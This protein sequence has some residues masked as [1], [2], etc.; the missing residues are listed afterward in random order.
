M[1]VSF[2]PLLLLPLALLLLVSAGCERKSTSSDPAGPVDPP[3][4]SNFFEVQYLGEEVR[5]I[6][7]VEAP[8]PS[9]TVVRG[10]DFERVSPRDDG[11][12]VRSF[13]FYNGR[14]LNVA[15]DGDLVLQGSSAFQLEQPVVSSIGPGQTAPFSITFMPSDLREYSATLTVNF[16]PNGG[17]STQFNIELFGRG[18]FGPDD[19]VLKVYG[20]LDQAEITSGEDPVAEK[21]SAFGSLNREVVSLAAELPQSIFTIANDGGGDMSIEL[22]VVGDSAEDFQ[23]IPAEMPQTPLG[24]FSTTSFTVEF[25]PSLTS[26]KDPRE[27]VIQIVTNDKLYDESP[28]FEVPLTGR[29][30]QSDIGVESLDVNLDN[31]VV[32]TSGAVPSVEDRTDMGRIP[33]GSI[34]ALTLRI[35]N[36]GTAELTLS[37]LPPIGM[38]GPD[39][40][41]ERFWVN[42]GDL[43]IDLLP[44]ESSNF[45][46][47]V[48]PLDKG[49]LSAW[50][51]ILSN[52]PNPRVFTINFQ[53]EAV[54]AAIG[55]EHFGQPVPSVDEDYVYWRTL[56][57][58]DEDDLNGNGDTE[59]VLEPATILET[60]GTSFGQA[61]VKG[62]EQTRKFQIVNN[63][64][65][66]IALTG[67]RPVSLTGDHASDFVVLSQPD[68]LT[69]ASGQ[70]SEF[71]LLFR[72]V[73][74]GERRA[75]VAIESD[76]PDVPVYL[77]PV[78]G[79]GMA[80]DLEVTFNGIKIENGDLEPSRNDGTHLGDVGV[81]TDEINR[82]GIWAYP[83]RFSGV[84]SYSSHEFTVTNVGN[85]D[86]HFTGSPRVEI[87]GVNAPVFSTPGVD[88]PGQSWGLDGSPQ[89]RTSVLK[90]GESD[91][92]TV[93]AN[94]SK[95][96]F[97]QA[98]VTVGSNDPSDD[99]GYS[100]AVGVRGIDSYPVIRGGNLLIP[101]RGDIVG[102]EDVPESAA[103]PYRFED[104]TLFFDLDIGYDDDGRAITHGPNDS[105]GTTWI[106][107]AGQHLA[108]R[109]Q[110]YTFTLSNEGK[111]DIFMAGMDVID[112]PS[113]RMS[114]AFANLAFQNPSM[115]EA[116]GTAAEVRDFD[117]RAGAFIQSMPEEDVASFDVTVSSD[118]IWDLYDAQRDRQ[119]RAREQTGDESINY[120]DIDNMLYLELEEER[121]AA[122]ELTLTSGTTRAVSY[123]RQLRLFVT[124]AEFAQVTAEHLVEFRHNGGVW[125]VAIDSL[126]GP[127]EETPLSSIL[128]VENHVPAKPYGIVDADGTEV[129]TFDA[130]LPPSVMIEAY[131]V[132]GYRTAFSQSVV[133]EI[134]AVSVG[135]YAVLANGEKAAI[136][137]VESVDGWFDTEV[138]SSGAAGSVVVALE[139][140][141]GDIFADTGGA[142]LPLSTENY[143]RSA[144]VDLEPEDGQRKVV[145]GNLAEVELYDD[146]DELL[147]TVLA[148]ILMIGTA[149]DD[150]DLSWIEVSFDSTA[151]SAQVTEIQDSLGNALREFDPAIAVSQRA[152]RYRYLMY[153]SDELPESVDGHKVE[154]AD[155]RLIDV[156]EFDDENRFLETALHSAGANEDASAVRAL[157]K[158]GTPIAS[159]YS[160]GLLRFALSDVWVHCEANTLGG[161]RE[162]MGLFIG[163][164]DREGTNTNAERLV[165]ILEVDEEESSLRVPYPFLFTDG[166]FG[167]LASEPF[168]VTR[169]TELRPGDTISMDEVRIEGEHVLNS[170]R[171]FTVKRVGYRYIQ[172]EEPVVS[173][174]WKEGEASLGNAA[175]ISQVVDME[176]SEGDV[177]LIMTTRLSD[178][179]YDLID[180]Q[181][182]RIT[183]TDS[184]SQNHM[185]S[186][187]DVKADEETSRVTIPSVMFDEVGLEVPDS[188]EFRTVRLNIDSGEMD[189]IVHD[190]EVIVGDLDPYVPVAGGLDRNNQIIELDEES[191]GRSIGHVIGSE[192]PWASLAG[193]SVQIE[194]IDFDPIT[195]I[196]HTPSTGVRSNV[197]LNVANSS[198]LD[199]IVAGSQV[200]LTVNNDD[201]TYRV[202]STPASGATSIRVQ[203][204]SGEDFDLGLLP[205]SALDYPITASVERVL[206]R[207]Y[208]VL[209]LDPGL[210]ML[211]F[212]DSQSLAGVLRGSAI[213]IDYQY[214]VTVLEGGVPVTR[215]FEGVFI[216]TVRQID[217]ERNGL[218]LADDVNPALPPWN[219]DS[220]I[221]GVTVQRSELT[222]LVRMV[223]TGS[224]AA[225]N[226]RSREIGF[227][228]SNED[229]TGIEPGS[230]FFIS[231]WP[232]SFTVASVD[233]DLARITIREGIDFNSLPWSKLGSLFGMSF[234]TAEEVAFTVPG[235]AVS[236]MPLG[237]SIS[238]TGYIRE[239]DAKL[240]NVISGVEAGETVEFGVTVQPRSTN[241]GDGSH[242][243]VDFYMVHNSSRSAANDPDGNPVYNFRMR[244]NEVELYPQ[245]FYRGVAGESKLDVSAP[246]PDD[247]NFP[248]RAKGTLFDDTGVGSSTTHLFRLY[249]ESRATGDLRLTDVTGG[250]ISLAGAN[251]EMFQV[252]VSG[253]DNDENGLMVLAPGEYIDFTVTFAPSTPG[254]KETVLQIPTSDGQQ[255]IYS[256]VLQG[257]ASHSNVAPQTSN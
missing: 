253:D 102:N 38:S 11:G 223:K 156:V 10:T 175:V 18:G 65:R 133:P 172:L 23:L 12:R 180:G 254:M 202:I 160:L 135:D 159:L 112:L 20:G 127:T 122:N 98:T 166:L 138:G 105:F 148:P 76:D 88:V 58:H 234:L 242:R 178:P 91:V 177:K 52:D 190:A 81:A 182:N 33:V 162:K 140:P 149:A 92:V 195:F 188:V 41:R 227:N 110:T 222:P 96:G 145:T 2:R 26:G 111:D 257:F 124:E 36:A 97:V 249:N 99:E 37:D 5:T 48:R 69:I 13:Q 108:S 7:T 86:L 196:S 147:A 228:S 243:Y 68:R 239:R 84:I 164:A 107:R 136:T 168:Y 53:V 117:F 203:L 1:A 233:T 224:R 216:S 39:D 238:E 125:R 29:V 142:Q 179:E 120:R 240:T 16:T 128:T 151:A 123:E 44:G 70:S 55:V 50:A 71:E 61:R 15:L 237:H 21:G 119:E 49:G 167:T 163:R 153:T 206:P 250:L 232:Q 213:S 209:E 161:V 137:K 229:L 32:L 215:T 197:D 219:D 214:E 17:E 183:F 51:N 66:T 56:P 24:G 64:S 248:I 8:D 192:S 35:V 236:T 101:D 194:A 225:I 6:A 89:P 132:R 171:D 158:N 256:V 226:P 113:G 185:L 103:D 45:Q 40:Q 157:D 152:H 22:S 42:T 165:R 116:V 78:L 144:S 230:R 77:F 9:A 25:R 59:E 93:G 170:D 186:Y 57:L 193:G 62:R 218:V 208:S 27:A 73:T 4:I 173:T 139:T 199:G 241:Q 255:A 204:E 244:F 43:D 3:T 115:Y 143:W 176:A 72:P 231:D 245:L 79:L 174:Y 54:E 150:D 114:D 14:S 187:V 100:F 80:P 134:S 67:T 235:H 90:P 210:P 246:I 126:E 169:Y 189:K 87:S 212:P 85:A 63:G 154:L 184:D 201:Y 75:V 251:H 60:N 129:L 95:Q 221:E 217:A 74:Y 211:V 31:A 198:E 83:T 200:I 141:N 146:A 46:V 30:V 130:A 94:P 106:T 34:G 191:G 28:Y 252:D 205:W 109:G 82:V 121:S 47:L 207:S 131:R 181:L 155:G 247:A 220:S 19:V 118:D 104:Q